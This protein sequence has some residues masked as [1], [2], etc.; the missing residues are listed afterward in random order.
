MSLMVMLVDKFVRVFRAKCMTIC[1]LYITLFALS[2]RVLACEYRVIVPEVDFPPAFMRSENG[3]RFGLSIELVEA[4]LAEA[5]CQI[6]Y[7]PAP[8]KRGLLK[9]KTGDADIMM[10]LSQTKE[11]E[12]YID[13]IGP[14]VDET[15]LLVV[16]KNSNFNIS[17]LDDIKKLPLAVGIGK[18]YFFGSEYHSKIKTD[19]EFKRKFE[20]VS[21]ESQNVEKLS[22]NRISAFIGP[23][24][25]MHYRIKNDYQ[26]KNFKLHSFDFYRDWVYY[27]LSKKSVSLEK[28]ISL[29]AAYLRAAKKGV[30]DKIQQRYRTGGKDTPHY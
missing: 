26:Y 9:L 17:T 21:F 14:Q 15:L 19:L 6:N 1:V 24:Y 20:A 11:R 13:F 22:R 18:G 23:S 16:N 29:E 5:S 27:G 8:F 30:F 2:F 25:N 28:K 3:N 4:L 7:I 12:Q 10:N